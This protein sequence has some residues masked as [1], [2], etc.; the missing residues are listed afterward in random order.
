[1]EGRRYHVL[2]YSKHVGPISKDALERKDR[3]HEV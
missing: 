3:E 2:C 1:V